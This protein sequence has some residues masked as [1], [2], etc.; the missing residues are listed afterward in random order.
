MRHSKDLL[1]IGGNYSLCIN[2]DEDLEY[3][4]EK[5]NGDLKRTRVS[6]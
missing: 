4:V 3:A 1:S 6:A 5:T 2:L